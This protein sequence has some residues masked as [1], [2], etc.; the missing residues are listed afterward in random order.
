[1]KRVLSGFCGL[2]RLLIHSVGL[3]SSVM[4]PWLT[5]SCSFSSILD[6][7]SIGTFLSGCTGFMLGS[8]LMV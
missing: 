8:V 5:I 1:M 6:W 7:S 2:V 3:V 4:I